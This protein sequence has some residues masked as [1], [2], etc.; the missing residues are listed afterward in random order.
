MRAQGHI[1]VWG[2]PA[3]KRRVRDANGWYQQLKAW[4]TAHKAE[5]EHARMAALDAC[6]D[7]RHE[8][9]RPL[10]ADA[11]AQGALTVAT[12]LYGLSQ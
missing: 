10:R 9:V 1:L 7:A 11:T 5:P 3:G 4:W 12:M 8:R 2:T 6:W